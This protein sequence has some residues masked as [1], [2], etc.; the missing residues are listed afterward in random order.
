MKYTFTD[1]AYPSVYVPAANPERILTAT[2]TTNAADEMT[3]YSECF[4]THQ[5]AGYF[6]HDEYGTTK[7]YVKRIYTDEC[8][9][10]IV[11]LEGRFSG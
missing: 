1:A 6:N 7:A 9:Q 2:I 8:E 10:T 4:E 11:E 5:S 3:F